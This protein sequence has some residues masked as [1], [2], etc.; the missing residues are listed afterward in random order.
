VYIPSSPENDGERPSEANSQ[1][2]EEEE[3]VGCVGFHQV[4]PQNA[5]ESHYKGQNR[6][7]PYTPYTNSTIEK[8]VETSPEANGEQKIGRRNPTLSTT[9][10]EGREEFVL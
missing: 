3:S 6:A 8:G 4:F 2:S 5:F 1:A 7:K 9:L 10:P